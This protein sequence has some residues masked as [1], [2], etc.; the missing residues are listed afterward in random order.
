MTD[1]KKK[2]GK[3]DRRMIN[4]TENY[5]LDFVAKKFNLKRADVLAAIKK[6]GNK[7]S[8]VYKFLRDRMT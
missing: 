4:S 7:R 6:V 2:K 5:E 8:E 1:N 3:Q